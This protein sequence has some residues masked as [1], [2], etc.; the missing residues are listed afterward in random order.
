ML[1]PSEQKFLQTY[2][3]QLYP[4]W[5]YLL[6]HGIAFGVVMII[7]QFAY[8]YLFK[9][10]LFHFQNVLLEIIVW[11]SGGLVYGWMMHWFLSRRLREIEKKQ[12]NS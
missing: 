1:S 8:R 3:K 4:K 9:K 11:L 2:K 12:P 10:E 5:K 7:F 6:A